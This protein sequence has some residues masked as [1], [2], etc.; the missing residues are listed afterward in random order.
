MLKRNRGGFAG[1]DVFIEALRFGMRG[2]GAPLKDEDLVVHLSQ[3]YEVHQGVLRF[4]AQSY[5]A[6]QIGRDAGWKVISRESVFNLL[7]YEEFVSANRSSK[8]AQ[9]S[10]FFAIVISIVAL[11]LGSWFSY[12]GLGSATGEDNGSAKAQVDGV[13]VVADEVVSLPPIFEPGNVVV[14]YG[15][16]T[17]IARAFL[18]EESRG[19]WVKDVLG[20]W[21]F[22]PAYFW[23]TECRSANWEGRDFFRWEDVAGREHKVWIPSLPCK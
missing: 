2:G 5:D 9:W 18:I 22:I 14:G 20:R 17:L 23:W 8:I 15:G 1:G 10:S 6:V 16:R 13:A 3:N 7:E 4:I 21:Y 12:I 11:G 19:D